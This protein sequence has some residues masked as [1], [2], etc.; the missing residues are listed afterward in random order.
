MVYFTITVFYN[1][2]VTIGAYWFI[3]R[4]RDIELQYIKDKHNLQIEEFR[5][6][7]TNVIRQLDNVQRINNRNQINNQ[8]TELE[9]HLNNTITKLQ[10]EL[11]KQS[12]SY[13]SQINNNVSSIM[14]EIKQDV[15]RKPVI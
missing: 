5:R 4:L 1:I 3:K 12:K 9:S 13:L 14:E 10:E 6:E 15:K 7:L 8:Y 11:F 2:L